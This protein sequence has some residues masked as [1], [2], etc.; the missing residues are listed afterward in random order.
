MTSFQKDKGVATM[1]YCRF[2]KNIIYTMIAVCSYINIV[3]LP[4]PVWA[5]TILKKEFTAVIDRMEEGITTNYNF[6]N[7]A[8]YDLFVMMLSL[9]GKTPTNSPQLF[10]SL[11]EKRR[12]HKAGKFK[13]VA[14]YPGEPGTDPGPVITTQSINIIPGATGDGAGTFRAMG[15]A[16]YE[17]GSPHTYGMLTLRDKDSGRLLV[18]EK[19]EDYGSPINTVQTKAYGD[20]KNVE[21]FF[22]GYYLDRDGNM[23]DFS[24]KLSAPNDLPVIKNEAPVSSTGRVSDTCVVCVNRTPSQ[25]NQCVYGKDNNTNA[26][27][28]PV[29]G[30]IAYSVPVKLDASRRPV[31]GA[32]VMYLVKNTGGGCIAWGPKDD[33]FFSDPQTVFSADKKNLNWNFA[34]ASFGEKQQCMDNGNVINFTLRVTTFDDNM[35]MMPGIL[36]STPPTVPGPNWQ[37]VSTITLIV[38]CLAQG[39]LIEAA[40]GRAMPVE[41]F[42]AEGEKVRTGTGAVLTVMGNTVGEEKDPMISITTEYGYNLMLTQG[43]PVVT[44]TAGIKLAKDLAINDVVLTRE[45]A[46]K[47]TS[48]TRKPYKGK[49]YNLMLGI[50]GEPITTDN[51]TF[52]ANGI[53]VGDLRMQETFGSHSANRLGEQDILKKLPK[54]WHRD[55]FNYRKAK[56]Q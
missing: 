49:V 8:E 18:W 15:M 48:V 52:F 2:T 10:R 13:K 5:T 12:M 32:A 42:Q 22:T 20:Y 30:N 24:E 40:D 47:L 27:K 31:G 51:T 7:D 54:E 46:Q 26:V 53:L 44:R 39:T 38:G 29:K 6:S 9:G 3:I 43:H 45:G 28:F 17:G 25:Q 55:Y 41:D 35:N 21:A 19:L 33:T 16:T 11:E 14:A 4:T 50:S 37:Q 23:I 34:P 56:K 36:T 1:G